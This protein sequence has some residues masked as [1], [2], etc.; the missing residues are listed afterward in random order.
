MDTIVAAESRARDPLQRVG[1]IVDRKALSP[2]HRRPPLRCS[3]SRRPFPP[4][5]SQNLSAPQSALPTRTRA[6]HGDSYSIV[7]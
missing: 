2:A 4:T 6:R 5:R 7:T 3:V 1:L